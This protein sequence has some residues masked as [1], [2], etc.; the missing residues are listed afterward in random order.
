MVLFIQ[1]N[2]FYDITIDEPF[3]KQHND[4]RTGEM[5][6]RDRALFQH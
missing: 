6:I 4:I 2:V 3:H 5:K 1:K